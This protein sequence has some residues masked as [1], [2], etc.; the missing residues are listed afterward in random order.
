MEVSV[1]A[2]DVGSWVPSAPEVEN[3]FFIRCALMRWWGAAARQPIN[4]PA[5]WIY[6][7]YRNVRTA[8][9]RTY[10]G[11]LSKEVPATAV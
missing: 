1:T 11:G 6:L 3:D 7:I 4:D 9:L 5:P 10:F 8:Y 2:R